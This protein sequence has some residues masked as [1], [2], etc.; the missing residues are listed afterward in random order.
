MEHVTIQCSEPCGLQHEL[1]STI[2]MA[3]GL[4]NK[5]T[6]AEYASDCSGA[7]N[8]SPSQENDLGL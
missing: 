8:A 4:K 1:M 6:L 2:Q 3:A 5:T 7:A